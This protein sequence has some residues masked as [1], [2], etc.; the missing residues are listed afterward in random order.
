MKQGSG[1][2]TRVDPA[3]AWM[4]ARARN[5][6]RRPLL[7][8]S[9]SGVAFLLALVTL[10]VAPRSGTRAQ[11]HAAAGAAAVRQDTVPLAAR[12]DRDRRSVAAAESALVVARRVSLGTIPAV[13]ADTFPPHLVA[14]RDSLTAS[15]A[16]LARLIARAQSTPLPSAY[17]ALGASRPLADNARVRVLLDSLTDVERERE[18]FGA[19]G[20]VDPIYVALTARV[21]EIGRS[22]LAVAEDVRGEHRREAAGLRMPPPSAVRAP[23]VAVLDTTPLA[24]IRDSAALA[25]KASTRALADARARN[26]GANRSAERAR[27]RANVVAP[28]VAILAAAIVLGA[29]FGFG[30]ALVLEMRRPRV[31]DQREAARVTGERVLAVIREQPPQPERMRRSAD[32]AVPPNVDAR[33]ESYRQ[34][35]G[36][37]AATGAAVPLVTITGDEPEIVAVVATNVAAVSAYESRGTL[38]V[39]ADLATGGVAAA[40][41]I[42]PDPGLDAVLAGTAD[43]AEAIASRQIGRDRVLDV[44]PAG[45]RGVAPSDATLPEIVKRDLRRLAR[46][47][48]FVVVAAPPIPSTGDTPPAV[49]LPAPDVVLCAR[50]GVTLV[51][52]LARS[53][54]RL[55]DAGAQIRG[56]VLWDMDPPTLPSQAELAAHFSPRARLE[57]ER[58]LAT[59]GGTH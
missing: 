38:L 19:V 53:A 8:G 12:R 45:T 28:P 57:R 14:R 49:G 33:A 16:A 55:R 11:R 36:H 37:L 50:V 21:T 5:A 47:F 54:Q 17:R 39:D 52:A 43:W 31:A 29:V 13:T 35:Y 22:L 24:A 26:A 40:L 42:R 59:A 56:I 48:D 27:E 58:E 25:L 41:R 20:G 4:S 7:I 15:A 34:I 23:A 10:V 51:S 1:D 18:A 3:A 32:R 9:V 30:V 44:I 46:R 6:L 2:F